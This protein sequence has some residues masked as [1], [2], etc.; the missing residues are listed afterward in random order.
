MAVVNQTR[1]RRILE[2]MLDEREFLGPYGIRSL[3]R[4]HDQHPYVFKTSD[5]E[6]K[7]SYLP[8]ESDTGMFGGNSNW[9]GPVWMPMNVLL[10]RALLQLYLY[11]GNDFKIECPTGSGHQ[12][13]LFDAARE[14]TAR[15]SRI[16]LRNE[17]GRRPVFA[18]RTSSRPTPLARHLLFYEYFHGDNGAGLGAAPDRRTGLIAPLIAL[19]EARREAL[20]GAREGGDP[21]RES[22]QRASPAK[23]RACAR[24]NGSPG[25]SMG[26]MSHRGRF[27]RDR[28]AGRW[29][30]ARATQGRRHP[31]RPIRN[32]EGS[33]GP[34]HASRDGLGF[35]AAARGEDDAARQH[36][37]TSPRE[38]GAGGAAQA[39]RGPRQAPAGPPQRPQRSARGVGR[40]LRPTQ[41]VVG[42]IATNNGPP[43]SWS[44]A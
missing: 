43:R 33:A 13:N 27:A 5:A 11:Y 4:F 22:R 42:T 26:R 20:P 14:I 10:I 32:R 1:L 24:L 44:S 28:G 18:A 41:D 37:N 39:L 34:R 36:S 9:R 25:G 23:G 40:V 2:K 7:V 16:F 38:P 21:A 30:R 31:G 17:Q 19:R 35:I 15:L 8:A 12:M 29:R 6:Y 3:S